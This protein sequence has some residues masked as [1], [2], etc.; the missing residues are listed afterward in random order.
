[1][2]IKQLK[3]HYY[4]GIKFLIPAGV[5]ATVFY[6]LAQQEQIDRRSAEAD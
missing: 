3:N 2:L 6:C 4:T 5:N 1:M